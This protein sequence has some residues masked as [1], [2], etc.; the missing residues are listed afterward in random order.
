MRC[1]SFYEIPIFNEIEGKEYRCLIE[2]KVLYLIREYQELL[3]FYLF[4]LFINIG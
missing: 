2:C 1:Y 4:L 3:L